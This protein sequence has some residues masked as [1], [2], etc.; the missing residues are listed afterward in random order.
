MLCGNYSIAT[1]ERI[2]EAVVDLE[3]DLRNSDAPNRKIDWALKIRYLR[4]D[5]HG[6]ESSP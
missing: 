6:A 4:R 2:Y 1:L 5:N 3:R